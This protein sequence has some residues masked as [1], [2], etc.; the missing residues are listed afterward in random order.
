MLQFVVGA[1]SIRRQRMTVKEG[2]LDTVMPESVL[3]LST[4]R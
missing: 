1:S 4:V 2:G 3:D